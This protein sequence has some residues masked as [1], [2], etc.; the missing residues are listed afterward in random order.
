MT[1][2]AA[3]VTAGR[4]TPSLLGQLGRPTN[5]S[6]NFQIV[7][8]AQRCELPSSLGGVRRGQPSLRCRAAVQCEEGGHEDDLEKESFAG[9]RELVFRLL[10]NFGFGQQVSLDGMGWAGGGHDGMTVRFRTCP[11]WSSH[12][13]HGLLVPPC[14]GREGAIS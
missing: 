3:A 11:V 8:A 6:W 10:G 12:Y 1:Q 14:P 9:Q 7:S 13:M 2:S 4:P 5:D